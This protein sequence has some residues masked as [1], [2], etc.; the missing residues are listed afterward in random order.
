MILCVSRNITGPLFS[1]ESILFV[2]ADGELIVG[3]VGT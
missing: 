1:G 2:F 3:W